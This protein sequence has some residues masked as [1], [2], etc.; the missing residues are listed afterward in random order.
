[1]AAHTGVSPTPSE[2]TA[3]AAVIAG[4]GQIEFQQ[5]EMPRP[6]TGDV[7]IRVEGCGVC[8]SNLEIWAGQPWF[9]YPMEPGGPGHEGWGYIDELGDGVNELDV[10]ERVAFLSGR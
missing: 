8:A 10:G 6:A 4:P 1:M 7:R 3:R 9:K 2:K 5:I